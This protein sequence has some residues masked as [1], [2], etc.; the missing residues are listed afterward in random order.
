M[1]YV[2][3]VRSCSKNGIVVDVFREFKNEHG[4]RLSLCWHVSSLAVEERERDPQMPTR[5][6][7]GEKVV[8]SS[9]LHEYCHRKV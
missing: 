2:E 9:I 1:M 5:G 4:A 8:G 7:R 3:C 6:S